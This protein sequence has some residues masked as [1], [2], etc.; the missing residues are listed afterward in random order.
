M[1]K[2]KYLLALFLINITSLFAQNDIMANFS[3]FYEYHK[4]KDY[5]SAEPYGWKVINSDPT[6]F[7]KFKLFPKMEETLWYLH[8]SAKVS[9]EQKKKLNDTILY[10]YDK[11]IQ[12]EPQL[13]GY[14]LA[15]K[16]YVMEVWLHDKPEK[17][18]PVYEKAIE[19]DPNLPAFYKDRLGLLYIANAADTNDYKL[20]A[21][22]LYSK[23]SEAEPDNQLWIQKLESIAENINELIDITKKSWDL[24][25]DNLEKAWKYAATCLR[26]QEYEKA[27]E[28]LEFLTTKAPDVVNYWKQLAS[29]YDKLEQNDKAIKAYRK[30]IELQP[31]GKENYV[32]LALI[33]KK[34]D[35]LSVARSFLQKAMSIDPNWDYP[36]LIEAQLYEQAARG[37]EFD[38]M[39]KCVY[40]LAVNTYK[41]AASMNGQ[42]SS[43]AADRV[44]ALQNSIPTKEDYFFRKLKSGDVIKIEGDCYSWIG[45]SVQVP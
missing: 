11:A 44:K 45:K 3:L 33:Y 36:V 4:N 13:E 19:K 8:D 23:L 43:L 9:D 24:D 2:V 16:A 34:M 18:I 15:R 17:I 37:C 27:K 38:F 5:V 10:F 7:V 14:Y 39:A 25:K 32:N 40:L 42:Y 30:L 35:Q 28:P 31:D 6:N 1:K 21:L 20:K 12:Y 22:D 26:A 29:V 41:K